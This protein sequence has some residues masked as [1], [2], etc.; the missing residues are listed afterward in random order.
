MGGSYSVHETAKLLN[1]SVASVYSYERKGVLKREEDPHH[2]KSSM[3]FSK[4]L[5]DKLVD[6][7]KKLDDSGLSISQFSKKVGVHEGKVKDAINELNLD[8]P[9]VRR[10]I[11]SNI[12]RYSL[13]QDQ[14]RQLTEYLS[15]QKVTRA[16]R[17][18]LYYPTP[19]IAL[20]QAF[21]IAGEQRVRL[22]LGKKNELGFQLD[23]E[24]FVPYTT[25][26]KE[27]DIEPVYG[28]HK[29]KQNNQQSFSDIIVPTGK[30]AFYQILDT[31]YNVCGV[32]NFNADFRHGKIIISV[33]NGTYPSDYSI[34]ALSAIQQYLE[35][36]DVE[37]SDGAWHFRLTKKIINLDLDAE[38]YPTFKAE[39]AKQRLS[40][41]GL[42]EGYLKDKA[43]ELKN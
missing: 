6:E 7:K 22:I 8:V 34:T 32:E 18:H 21:N 19:D 2:L 33:R 27:F 40:V 14:E 3:T 43:A 42:L 1:L 15:R 30:K 4:E 12:M 29:E 23:S 37:V 25:A 11:Y 41:K 20:Y 36:G 10:S 35:L 24:T 39:A 28:I 13:T 9:M 5:V 17:N 26:I 16:K 38:D 31:I